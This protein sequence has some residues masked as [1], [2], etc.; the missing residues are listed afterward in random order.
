MGSAA[1]PS[2]TGV[3]VCVRARAVRWMGWTRWPEA[4]NYVYQSGISPADWLFRYQKS[5]HFA[6]EVTRVLPA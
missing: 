4:P 5:H 2:L 6:T 1:A 3:G